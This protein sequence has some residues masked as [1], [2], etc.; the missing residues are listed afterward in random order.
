L[1]ALSAVASGFGS[2]WSK[3]SGFFSSSTAAT[4]A[5]TAAV[6]ENA[7]AQTASIGALDAKNAALAENA[8]ATEASTAAGDG[9]AASAGGL[10]SVLGPL[11]IGLGVVAVAYEGYTHSM[12]EN[13]D[14]Q[15]AAGASTDELIRVYN[16]AAQSFGGAGLQYD[17]F[18]KI[19]DTSLGTVER[20]RD[21]LKAQGQDTAVLDG[22]ITQHQAATAQQQADQQKIASATQQTNAT[23]QQQAAVYKQI[24]SAADAAF[25]AALKLAPADVRAQQSGLQ[26]DDAKQRLSDAQAQLQTDEAAG[27][28]QQTIAADYRAVAAAQLAVTQAALDQAD[29]LLNLK[30]AQDAANGKVDDAKT[31][32][33]LYL[34]ILGQVASEFNGPTRD[35]LAG[36]IL[37]TTQATNATAALQKQ[38]LSGVGSGIGSI[39]APPGGLFAQIPHFAEGGTVPGAMGVPQ[40]AVVHGGEKVLTPTQQQETGPTV[41]QHIHAPSTDAFEIAQESSYAFASQRYLA[42][43]GR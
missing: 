26:V 39:V 10:T 22:I 41:I 14:V 4:D 11:A 38:Q 25:S 24:E 7:G 37:Q 12:S 20:L 17:T 34:G 15:K 16:A 8:A 5:N 28:T 19:A 9:A 40:L 29:A 2:V 31:Q 42:A 21:A 32:D 18:N 23:L 33:G 35:A 27:A 13:I 36:Y 6:T 3:V 1:T 30:V 43:S